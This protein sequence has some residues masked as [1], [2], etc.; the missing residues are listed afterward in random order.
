M[1]SFK[2]AL[3]KQQTF[4][5]KGVYAL[6]I[7]ILGLSLQPTVPVQASSMIFNDDFENGFSNWV[8]SGLWNPESESDLCGLLHAPFP[9]PTNAAYYGNDATCTYNTGGFNTGNL[10]MAS[11]VSL[12]PPAQGRTAS[13]TFWSFSNTNTSSFSTLRMILISTDGGRNWN[14]LGLDQTED[15]WKSAHLKPYP[16]FGEKRDDPFCIHQSGLF[17][18]QQ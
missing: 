13:L 16:L 9:S 7:L 1:F 3:Q 6:I 18:S 8:M 5:R 4:I 10:T 11:Q 12:P 15:A 2:L 14:Y 17:F